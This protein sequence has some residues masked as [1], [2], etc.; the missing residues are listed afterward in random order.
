[1]L[2]E[3][4]KPF[5]LENTSV[6]TIGLSI[7]ITAVAPYFNFAVLGKFR[8]VKTEIGFVGAFDPSNPAKN[9]IIGE[10]ENLNFSTLL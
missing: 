8:L 2:T 4:V 9:L 1:M 7:G 10:I 3:W 5:G 6:K